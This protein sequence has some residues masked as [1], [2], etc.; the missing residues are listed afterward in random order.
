[1]KQSIVIALLFTAGLL[2]GI[3]TGYMRGKGVARGLAAG[4]MLGAGL[5]LLTVPFYALFILGAL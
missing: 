2:A 1:V 4:I 5:V 3:L